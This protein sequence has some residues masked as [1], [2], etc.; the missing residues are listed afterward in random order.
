MNQQLSQRRAEAVKAALVKRG[1]SGD[2]L[3]TVG[4]G[5]AQPIAPNRSAGGRQKNRRVEFI[6]MGDS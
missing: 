5:E 3:E 1:I 6:I 4:V 2:R